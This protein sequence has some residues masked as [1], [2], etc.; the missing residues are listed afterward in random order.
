VDEAS[1]QV[2]SQDSPISTKT[3]ETFAT[4]KLKKK[5][6]N[7]DEWI[8]DLEDIRTRMV[9]MGS[10]MSD[11]DLVIHVLNNLPLIYEIEVSKLED[12]VGISSNPLTVESMRDTLNLKYEK[13]YGSNDESSDTSDDESKEG[14]HEKALFSAGQFKG[15][16]QGCGKY[17][18]KHADCKNKGINLNHAKKDYKKFTGDCNYCHKQGHKE[19]ECFKKKRDK[20]EHVGIAADTEDDTEIVLLGTDSHS[21]IGLNTYIADSGASCHTRP[22]KD[23]MPDLKPI[24]EEITIGDGYK[25]K[26]THVGTFKGVADNKQKVIIRTCKVVPRLWTPLFSITAALKRGCSLGNEG[27]NITISKGSFKL[28]FD[29]T[30]KTKDGFLKGVNLKPIQDKENEILQLAADKDKQ[31]SGHFTTGTRL[32][33]NDLHRLLNHPSEAAT[34][35]TAK[36]YGWILNG[37]FDK[38]EHC[39]KAKAKQKNLNKVQVQSSSTRNR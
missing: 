22:N 29:K 3:K 32:Q 23:G 37:T 18:H 6:S 8:T 12:R 11:I 39:L 26:A 17:G 15:T 33:I 7:P 35:K 2:R 28:S 30:I 31:L 4:S 34:R 20:G 5:E 25:M 14:T 1:Q 21:K 9:D 16:C 10:M 13:L 27:T 19:A 36:Y 24:H 38:C